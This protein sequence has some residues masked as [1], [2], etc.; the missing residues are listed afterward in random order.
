MYAGDLEAIETL[1]HDEK[2]HK[3]AALD[4][5]VWKEVITYNLDPSDQI[6]SLQA[7]D[8]ELGNAVHAL[9]VYP[10][11]Q[12]LQNL[13]NVLDAREREGIPNR[14]A[15]YFA[16]SQL[17]NNMGAYEF[18]LPVTSPLIVLRTERIHG[19]LKSFCELPGRPWQWS[20]TPLSR[21]F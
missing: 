10:K 5:E 15:Y 3:L 20:R 12:T 1:R 2:I 6:A 11:S 13:S 21:V 19:P 17:Q 9:Q 16:A 14:R 18:P 4:P 8:Q 7:A